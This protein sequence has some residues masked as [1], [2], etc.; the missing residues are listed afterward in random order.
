MT[1]TRT[2]LT[3]AGSDSSGG[4]GIQADLKAIA[5][6]GGYGAS[7]ITAITAQ[8]TRG[9]IRAE[10]V[11]LEMVRAQ[12]DAVLG[13]L[14]IAAVKSGMLATAEV[15]G[16][17]AE[18]LR[19]MKA[20]Y[21]CDPVMV[22][23]GGH[24]LLEDAAVGAVIR[25]L[26]PLAAVV[27]PNVHEAAALTGMPVRTL[28]DAEAAGRALLGM[29]ARAALVKGGHL[30]EGTA[31]DVL[32]TEA[33]ARRFPAPLLPARHTHGT[34]CTYAAAIAAHLGQGLPL[35]EA[36]ALSKELVTEAIRHGLEV[37][38]GI[39]PT[40]PFHFLQDEGGGTWLPRMRERA[41]R[42]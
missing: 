36:V 20:P 14:D 28:A 7:V 39:G 3:I 24:R 5:A 23:K 11:S 26:L 41:R 13:D 32:V 30:E 9:V 29:G 27:T 2:I 31:T 40:D 17:V 8:N 18:A 1:A 21:V 16:V 15:I 4:A 22:A 33:G 12:L 42:R 34:G 6:C 25:D 35:E 19:G 38:G 10:A 37:G